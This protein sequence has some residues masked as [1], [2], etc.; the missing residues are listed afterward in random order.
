MK[1]K[2][3]FYTVAS[4]LLLLPAMVSAQWEVSNDGALPDGTIYEIIR[5]IMNWLLALVGIIGVIGFVIAGIIYLTAAGDS[6]K[7]E[8]AK[9]AMT[10][11]IIGVIVALMGFVIIQAV[12][13]MLGGGT[14]TF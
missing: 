10:Y 2:K 3:T 11:S 12:D 9:N 4:S 8:T 1:T 13:A 7:A 14:S 5:S 6:S